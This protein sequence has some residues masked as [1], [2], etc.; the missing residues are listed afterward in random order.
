V[1]VE[2]QRRAEALDEGD[3]AALLGAKIPLPACAPAQ[4]GEERADEGAQNF[5]RELRIVGAA[6]AERV[7]ER[8]HPMPDRG[9]GQGAIDQLGGGIRHPA[10]AAGRT[11]AP[12]LAGERHQPVVTTRVAVDPNESVRE[13]ATAEVRAKLLLDEARGGLIASRGARQ[14][15]LELLAHHP[16]EKRL[17]GLV[18]RVLGHEVPERDRAVRE[19]RG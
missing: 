1:Q 18:S 6:V 19:R 11:E 5:A 17:L 9:L 16:V 3:G 15:G 13:H 10:P 12:P 2:V 7:R 4:L 8:Q 14:E